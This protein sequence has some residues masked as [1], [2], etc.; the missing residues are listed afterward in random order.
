[1]ALPLS[2]Q[3]FTI[4]A[5]LVE[6]RS[7]LH[8]GSNDRDL[9]A[10]KVSARCIDAGFE[11]LLD[12]YYFMRYDPG[13]DEELGRLVDSLL[14]HETY[15]FREREQLEWLVD[16]FLA[17][18][19]AEGRRPRVWSAACATG[20]EPLT[21]AMLLA[22]R[23]LAG[24]VDLVAT[25][26]S[27]RALA[28]AREGVY[29][30]RALRHASSSELAGRYLSERGG[31]LIVNPEIHRAVE[32]RRVNLIVPDEVR[33]L[34]AFDAVVCRNVLIYF[35]DARTQEVIDALTARLV[36]DGVLLVGVSES[37]LRFGSSVDCQ[38]NAGVFVY[39]PVR[40]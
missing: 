20:E 35:S 22:A 1:M 33:A 9:F 5:A 17:P 11:S 37:L 8:Y 15:F 27:E 7:G 40:R 2:P 18:R 38:E 13:G 34:G 10:E 29:P 25:D 14:V 32:W 21:M 39:R 16:R 28:R 30:P 19:V 36:D 31:R 24:K 4:L 23:G 6:G 3:V 12:Y 26:V